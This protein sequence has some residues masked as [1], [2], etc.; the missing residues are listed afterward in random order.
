MK[1]NRLALY[2]VV[3]GLNYYQHPDYLNWQI[4]WKANALKYHARETEGERPKSPLSQLKEMKHLEE[5]FRR[6]TGEPSER[7]ITVR[8]P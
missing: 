6:L 2:I 4:L 7:D 5:E 8:H 1:P 3:D